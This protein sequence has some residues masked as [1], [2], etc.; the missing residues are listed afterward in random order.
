MNA[1]KKIVLIFVTALFILAVGI[2]LFIKSLEPDWIKTYIAKQITTITGL[3]SDIKGSITWQ[4]LPTPGL[5]VHQI[6]VGSAES[7]KKLNLEIKEL[8]LKLQLEPL[9]HGRLTFSEIS[10]DGLNAVINPNAP[11]PAI[12]KTE[13]KT[14]KE[15]KITPS[16]VTF[17]IDN[18]RL[19]DGHIKFMQDNA[20]YKL[21]DVHIS[22]SQLNLENKYFPLQLKSNLAISLPGHSGHATL[23]YTG[24]IKLSDKIFYL[25]PNNLSALNSIGHLTLTDVQFDQ[26]KIE[27]ITADTDIQNNNIQ[28]DPIKINLYDGESIGNASYRLDTQAITVNQTATNL[29]LET[30]IQDL[31]DK[32]LIVGKLDFTTHGTAR[33]KEQNGLNSLRVNGTASIKDGKLLFVDIQALVNELLNRFQMLL[34]N[35]TID[36]QTLSEL[37]NLNPEDFQKGITKFTALNVTYDIPQPM[38]LNNSL[39]LQ[40]RQFELSGQGSI[41]LQQQS[42]NNHLNLKLSSNHENAAKINDIFVD[43]IPLRLK[44]SLKQPLVYP[45]VKQISALLTKHYLKKTLNKPIKQLKEE[46]KG[47]FDTL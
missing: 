12:I 34:N 21:N 16:R 40:T 4:I 5:K 47:F 13:Y 3:P 11:A 8:V 7:E 19:T 37:A 44:G 29:N 22:L 27:K 25:A 46:V 10:I 17:A 14:K 39:V 41:N 28:F 9:L 45:D 6:Q 24:K 20:Q 38:L 15:P 2:W 42:I 23:N 33:L 31:V 30:F 1:L 32:K 18:F 26:F 43:G 35:S 36:P